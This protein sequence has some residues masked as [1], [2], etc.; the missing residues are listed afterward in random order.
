MFSKGKSLMDGEALERQIKRGLNFFPLANLPA[1]VAS[2][3]GLAGQRAPKHGAIS[4]Q[5]KA[6]GNGEH[7]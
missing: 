4:A 7:V 6:S 2:R 1:R 3:G 5:E